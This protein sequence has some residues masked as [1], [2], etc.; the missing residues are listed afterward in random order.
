[1]FKRSISPPSPAMAVALVALFVALGG[2]GYAATQLRAPAPATPAKAKHK[3]KPTGDTSADKTLFNQLAA[4]ATVAKANTANFATTANAA[5]MANT[6]N[7]ANSATTAG[8]AGNANTVGGLPAS[9]FQPAA[10]IM[11]ATVNSSATSPTIAHGRG[12]TAVTNLDSKGEYGVTF[13]QP[14]ANCTWVATSGHSTGAIADSILAAVRARDLVNH[15]NDVQVNLFT[16]FAGN[17][18]V[19]QGFQLM[20]LCP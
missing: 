2:T 8:S 7:T 19:G 17:E 16:D 14:I 3:P 1:M 20:V 15:P 9:T 13:N 11:F 6:A 4:T 10:K 12:A 18:T 5:T